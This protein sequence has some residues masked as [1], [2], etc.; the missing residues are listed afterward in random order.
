MNTV[1]IRTIQPHDNTALAK[2]IRNSLEEFKA[3]KPGTVYFDPTT[4][5]LSAVF[6][7]PGSI[8]FVAEDNAVL[9]GGSGIYPTQNLPAGTCELV[10]LYLSNVAR[11]KGLGKLLIEKCFTAAKELGYTKMYLETLPELN[12]AV[13]LYEK[14]GF[15]YLENPLGDSGHHG[16]DIWMIKDL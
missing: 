3:N 7:A 6:T 5:N 12:I 2:I 1:T 4:D 9:L 15:T 11:G 13:P 16:C 10:K 14:M 8:Y